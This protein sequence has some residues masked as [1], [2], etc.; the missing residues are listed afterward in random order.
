MVARVFFTRCAPFF[1]VP[2]REKKM[3]F[4]VLT[5]FVA[6]FAIAFAEKARFDNYRIYSVNIEN[7]QQLNVLHDLQNYPD[8]ITFQTIPTRVGQLAHLIVPP[9]KFADISELFEA[10]KFKN[11]IKT[12][13][14]Q[15]FV[16]ADIN[17]SDFDQF[18]NYLN[19]FSNLQID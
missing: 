6:C 17:S 13:N 7:D 4:F 8:G 3:K 2:K 14:L 5:I 10:Y 15:R 1:V 19:V 9:H 12:K 16:V 18:S 11:E